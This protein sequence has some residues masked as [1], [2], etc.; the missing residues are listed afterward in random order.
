MAISKTLDVNGARITTSFDDP[1][2]PLLYLLRDNLGLHGPRFGCGL[3]QCGACTVHIHGQ[4]V[5]Q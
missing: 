5:L 4:A 3:A 2:M 1:G